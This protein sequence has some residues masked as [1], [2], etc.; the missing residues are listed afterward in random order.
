MKLYNLE[1]FRKNFKE[2]TELRVQE[3]NSLSISL[4]QGDVSKNQKSSSSGVS[5][6]VFKNG[7][8]GFA[9]DPII[10]KDSINKT[11]KDATKNSEFLTEKKGKKNIILPSRPGEIYKNF[12]TD[13]KRINQK[14][15]IEFLKEVDNY[16]VKNCP[17]VSSRSLR[18]SNL[19]ME[20][21]IITS[22]GSKAY[23][24]RP[25]SLVIISLTTE[26]SNEPVSLYEVYGGFGEFE[27]N[28]NNPK[29]VFSKVDKLYSDLMDKA[30]GVYPEA[31]VHECI[32]DAD[33]AGILAHEAIGH[34]TEADMVR[35]GSIAGNNLNKKVASELITL[36]D[37]A[38]T[39]NGDLCPVPVFIDDEGIKAEDAVIIKDGILKGFM[40]NKESADYFDVAPTGNARAYQY[41]DEPLIRM[42]NTAINPGKSK[43]EDMISS[44]DDGYYLM[45][46]SN[47]QA[48]STSE[49]MF[50]IIKGYKIKNGKIDKAIRETTISGIAF[51]V[52]KSVSMVSDDMSWTSAGM[53][54][55]KQIIPVGMGGPAVKCKINIGGK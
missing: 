39:Y 45:K 29:K 14:Q 47:G 40:H 43:L 8:W 3:N 35:N 46:P 49:F 17:K 15:L 19:N 7:Y 18:I 12:S 9:S 1:K 50:G 48:D 26:I 31:G 2:Y 52:L 6:R 5:T 55:K 10:N 34:T 23:V 33:L 24:F 51:D 28:F 21:S 32:L 44:I 42:R 4:L 25:R 38:N 37:Y 20:K 13:K 53:C 41:Y 22:D 54:G 11:I 27:D 16:I 30:E 36:T